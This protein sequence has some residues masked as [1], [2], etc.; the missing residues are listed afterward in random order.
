ME[1]IGLTGGIGSG[2]ST[3][4]KYI[5]DKGFKIIDADKISKEIMDNNLTVKE[6][7]IKKFGEDILSSDGAIDRK[8]IA[9]I[10]FN[11]VEK[12][13]ELNNIIHPEIISNIDIKIDEFKRS[14]EE[15]IFLDVPLLFETGL[16]EKCDEI[17]VVVANEEKRIERVA[18]R[19]NVS[20]EEVKARMENQLSDQ[21]KIQK[22][23]L[24]LSNNLEIEDLYKI[25]DILLY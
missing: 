2:K 22:G 8:K 4:S 6:N 18:K 13:D 25:L 14:G 23:S 7:V 17:W 15:K 1:I 5:S 10:V 16:D 21:E 9:D 24:V 3:V 19:D 12:L 20:A 11:Y